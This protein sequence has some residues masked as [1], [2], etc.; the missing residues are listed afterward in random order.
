MIIEIGK[1]DKSDED[2]YDNHRNWYIMITRIG[3]NVKSKFLL[4]VSKQFYEDM[5]IIQE[6]TGGTTVLDQC[7]PSKLKFHSKYTSQNM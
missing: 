5:M 6:D 3:K 4:P 7:A 1:R 2:T